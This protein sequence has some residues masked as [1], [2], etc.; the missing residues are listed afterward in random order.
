MRACSFGPQSTHGVPCSHPPPS[1]QPPRLDPQTQHSL[2]NLLLFG[3]LDRAA[4]AKIADHTWERS[5]S[6]GEILIQEGEVGLAASELYVVKS[7]K[8]EVLERR[9][10]VNMRVNVKERGD[11]FGEVSLLYNCPRTATV[12]ATTDAVVW[13]L[14]RDVFRK[15]VQEAAE[16]EVGQIELFLNS[17]PLL[18]PLSRAAKLQLVDAFLEETFKAGAVIIQEGDPGDKFY[19]VKA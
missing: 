7:G 8:F 4:Q 2:C 15:Y 1:T 13:V 6:A 9:K 5:V 16:G 18:S 3:R 12:A 17:V 19:I 10:G 11:V 14:E